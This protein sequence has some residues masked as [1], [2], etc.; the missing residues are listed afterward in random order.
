M[1][2]DRRLRF[3][4]YAGNNMFN[5]LGNL[6]TCPRAGLLFVDFERGDLV[7]MTGRTRL[8]SDL[9]VELEIDEVVEMPGGSSLRWSLVEY[10]PAN[11]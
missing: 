7:S 6:Q 5:T 1:V 2:D 8:D 9:A 4:N 11:P 3:P 10:S